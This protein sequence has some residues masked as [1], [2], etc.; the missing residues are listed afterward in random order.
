M[1]SRY[2]YTRDTR[3]VI[4]SLY[5]WFTELLH[6]VC[7]SPTTVSKHVSSRLIHVPVMEIKVSEMDRFIGVLCQLCDLARVKDWGLFL[8]ILRHAH[9]VFLSLSLS[10]SLSL[11]VCDYVVLVFVSVQSMFAI[12]SSYSQNTFFLLIN[13]LYCYFSWSFSR[14][15]EI[16]FVASCVIMFTPFFHIWCKYIRVELDITVDIITALAKALYER[17][18]RCVCVCV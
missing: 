5:C 12:L 17:L 3:V 10:L 6:P 1:L 7:N 15:L 13:L 8:N 9:T 14:S 2:R 16:L 4:E 18:F 11:G